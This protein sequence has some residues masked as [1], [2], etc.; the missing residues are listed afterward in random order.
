MH[1]PRLSLAPTP[2]NASPLSL[3]PFDTATTPPL[4]PPPP[5]PRISRA[6]ATHFTPLPLPG[7]MV[8][9][10]TAWLTPSVPFED[11]ALPVGKP[12]PVP[13]SGAPGVSLIPLCI[14]VQKPAQ[15]RLSRPHLK[16]V[17][18]RRT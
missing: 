5:C 2:V 7:E 17:H 13:G 6:P 18:V 4:S 10:R 15:I 9:G 8:F 14:A 3:L 12:V 16:P 1:T 11:S